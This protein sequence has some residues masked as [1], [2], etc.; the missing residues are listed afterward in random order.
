VVTVIGRAEAGSAAAEAKPAA[1]I[2]ANRANFTV[3]GIKPG[4]P[5]T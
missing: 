5:V 2:I 4:T 1:T 3:N